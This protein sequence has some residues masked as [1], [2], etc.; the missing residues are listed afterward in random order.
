MAD[1]GPASPLAQALGVERGI[2]PHVDD[3]GMCHGGN[4]AFLEL[5]RRRLVTCGSVM[6]PCPWFAEIAEAAVAEPVLDLGV[7]LTLTSEWAHYRWRPLSTA[8]AASGLIDQDGYFWRDV[9]SLRRHLV[10]EA[11]AVEL[12]MQVERA[13]AAGLR[14]SHLDAHMAAAMLPELL[15]CYIALAREFGLVPVL[16]RRIGFAPDPPSYD[17]TV[18]ALEAAGLPLPDECRSTLAVPPEQAWDGYRDLIG[19]LPA[20]ITHLALHC[21]VPGDIEA[22]TPQHAPWRTREYSLLADGS[23]DAWCR[24][25][26][27][28][29]AGYRAVQDIWLARF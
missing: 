2:I 10:A 11:A 1:A 14:P 26:G 24:A 15:H 13:V 29:L 23:I 12:R 19:S 27:V 5:S 25:A 7:H 22:I 3:L 21:A 6:V 8:S 17:S 20:G 16:P 18:A 9:R 4:L 28:A